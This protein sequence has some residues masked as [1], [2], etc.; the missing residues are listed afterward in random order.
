MYTIIAT[1]C[2]YGMAISPNKPLCFQ[3]STIPME[4]NNESSCIL[5]RD[6]LAKD[7]HTDFNARNVKAILYCSEIKK[8]DIEKKEQHYEQT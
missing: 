8:D 5:V 6:R 4:F 2:F 1:L 3:K 7:L